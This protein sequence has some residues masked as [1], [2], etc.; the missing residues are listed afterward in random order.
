MP[1]MPPAKRINSGHSSPNSKERMVPETAPMANSTPAVRAQRRASVRYV[2]SPVRPP[3]SAD[4]QQHAVLQAL[5]DY[6]DFGEPGVK[7]RRPIQPQRRPRP[8]PRQTAHQAGAAGQGA[9]ERRLLG[10]RRPP[11]IP[12]LPPVG[13]K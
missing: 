11:G 1:M 8:R 5:P 9:G 13:A 6:F 4:R 12:I 10:D 2:T 3:L 7:Q